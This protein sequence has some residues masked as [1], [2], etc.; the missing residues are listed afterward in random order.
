MW[1]QPTLPSSDGCRHVRSCAGNGAGGYAPLVRRV[2]VGP[3]TPLHEPE[4]LPS[5]STLWASPCDYS[6][7]GCRP[8]ELR[9]LVVQPPAS[10]NSWLSLTSDPLPIAAAYEWAVLPRVWCRRAVQR[11]GSRPCSRRA[12]CAAR[13]RRVADVRGVR[14]AGRA[15]L[16][17][18]RCRTAS[19]LAGNRQGR[20]DPPHR[21]L[22]PR[23]ELRHR[24]GQRSASC[25]GVRGCPIC[26]RRAEVECADLEA[27]GVA[28][29]VPIGA[30]PAGAPIDAASV[31]TSSGRRNSP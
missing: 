1:T 26:H 22:G 23:R 29:T 15:A 5:R 27:R 17:G 2:V 8:A 7:V 19:A 11:H 13:P 16:R 28:A 21:Q 24:R 3:L 31:P 6:G 12:R 30:S 18:H 25:R 10:G 14:V 4:R 20:A 9:W